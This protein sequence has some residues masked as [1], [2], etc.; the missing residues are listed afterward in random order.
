MSV[1]LYDWPAQIRPR[2]AI[3]LATSHTIDGFVSRASYE[4][5]RPIAGSRGQMRMEF[6]LHGADVGHIY[7]WLVNNAKRA[8]WLV[9]V[10]NTPQLART[11]AMDAAEATY[12]QGLPFSTGEFFSTGYGFLFNPSIDVKTAALEGATTI[13]LDETRWPDALTYGKVFGIGRVVYHVD[14]IERDGTD[15]TITFNPPLRRD[16]TAGELVTLRPKMI[17]KPKNAGEFIALFQA[18]QLFTPGNITMN[19]VIDEDYL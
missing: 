14:L 16:V 7:A 6:D 19:E 5:E 2:A 10:F 12:T 8:R 11:A 15:V 18:P 13:V 3:A 9:P 4:N 1:P 17:C